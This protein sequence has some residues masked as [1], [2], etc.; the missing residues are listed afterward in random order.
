[1]RSGVFLPLTDHVTWAEFEFEPRFQT[2]NPTFS[3]PPNA[4][5]DGMGVICV[6]Y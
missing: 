1:M 3:P 2:P 6:M 4:V 5:R